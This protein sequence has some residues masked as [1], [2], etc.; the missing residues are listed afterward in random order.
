VDDEVRVVVLTG[1][2]GKAFVLRRRYFQVRE[3]AAPTL[4]ATRH[5]NATVEKAYGRDSSRFP[6]RTIP[7]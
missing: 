6:S 4:E 5:Y 3:R 2:G 1:A 7:P